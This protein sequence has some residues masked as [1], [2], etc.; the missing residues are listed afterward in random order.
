[1][2]EGVQAEERSG[3]FLKPFL[4]AVGFL[5]YFAITLE[6]IFMVTPFALYYY[7]AYSPF[8]S[9]ASSV[10]G[11][12]WL[13]AFFLPHLSTEVVPS[14]GGLIVLVGVCGFLI[15]AIQIYYAKFRKRGVVKSGF[16]KRVRHPQYL[17]LGI[18]GFGLLIVWPRF[19]LLVIFVNVLWFYYLLAR[20]EEERMRLRFGDAYLQPMQSAPMF[21]PGEPGR[22]LA[23][24]LFGWIR[25]RKLRLFVL[26]C[27]SL[28][29]AVAVAFAL[30]SVSLGSTTH[31]TLSDEKIAA[32]SFLS[33]G[34]TQVRKLVQSAQSN[35]EIQDRI[36]REN[37]WT[38]IQA[39]DGKASATHV[40]IDA[41]MPV[42]QVRALPLATKGIK[43]VLSRRED[44]GNQDQPFESKARW[45]P[46]LIAELDGTSVLRLIDLPPKFFVGNPVMP[47]F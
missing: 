47:I 2:A 4:R 5:A 1:M 32:V 36:H 9:A 23:Q 41:G 21:M 34:Q 20:N 19:I 39:L 44:Q 14:I 8:L 40:M 16:Y 22:R 24:M 10:H 31:V 42:R 7:S 28:G 38:L 37:S 12:A 43:L 3:V 33:G 35:R 26:Y 46:F 30:R 29:G 15:G 25:A 6:M 45:R 17:F 27:A 11:L 13:P 18:A